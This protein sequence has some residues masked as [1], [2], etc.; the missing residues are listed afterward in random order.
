LLL[1]LIVLA[2]GCG[3]PRRSVEHVTVTGQV[4]FK[5]KPLPGGRVTF[6][7]TQGA[8]AS[9]GD[10]DEQ[11]NYKVTAPAGEVKIGVDNQMLSPRSKGAPASAA[12]GAGRP[13]GA[14]ATLPKGTY[15][16]IPRKYTDPE[17]SGLTYTVTKGQTSHNIDLGE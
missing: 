9:T 13:N 15:V 1:C 4:L 3:G 6:V 8:F 12:K 10:I 2:V 16:A 11:G 7:T 17:T 14:E 5:G